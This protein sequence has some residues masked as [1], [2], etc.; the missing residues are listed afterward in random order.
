[1]KPLSAVIHMPS[2][3]TPRSPCI[4]STDRA[5]TTGCGGAGPNCCGSWHYVTPT[6]SFI[7]S[8]RPRWRT[9]H[10]PFESRAL[11]VSCTVFIIR[12]PGRPAFGGVER[13]RR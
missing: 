2:T 4:H 3:P 9:F 12:W 1:M 7:H 13:S 8:F 11:A 6:L 5:H 10:I